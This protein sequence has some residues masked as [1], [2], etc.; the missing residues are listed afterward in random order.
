[1][2]VAILLDADADAQKRN[3]DGKTPADLA[4]SGLLTGPHTALAATIRA[5]E[6][7]GFFGFGHRAP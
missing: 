6:K 1:V 3:K 4:D 7:H 5:R 2:I